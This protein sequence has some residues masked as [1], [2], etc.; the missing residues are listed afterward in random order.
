MGWSLHKYEC[1]GDVEGKGRNSNLQD[2]ALY[3]YIYL[4][5]VRVEILSYIKNKKKNG[6]K[7]ITL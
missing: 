3:I 6:E 7:L 4:D 2:R 5:Y 1:L